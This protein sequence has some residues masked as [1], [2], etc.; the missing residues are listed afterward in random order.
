MKTADDPIEKIHTIYSTAF[1]PKLQDEKASR[2]QRIKKNVRTRRRILGG[3]NRRGRRERNSCSLSLFKNL[4][5]ALDEEFKRAEFVSCYDDI[6]I[7]GK[8]RQSPPE[9]ISR[10]IFLAFYF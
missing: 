2:N 4:D 9:M 1:C 8:S 3:L 5:A 6:V 7:D 10:V